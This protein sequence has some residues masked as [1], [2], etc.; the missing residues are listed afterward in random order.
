MQLD[1]Y[2][3]TREAAELLGITRKS[4]A[5]LAAVVEV[6]P[7][8]EQRVDR[9]RSASD[10]VPHDLLVAEPGTGLDRVLSVKVVAIII[11]E[12]CGYP[13]LRIVCVR[14]SLLLLGYQNHSPV[15]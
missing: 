11:S 3:D 4:V 12:Y 6:D 9:A 8:L 5:R 13:A 7:V 2:M 10:D 14:L 15:A 1:D